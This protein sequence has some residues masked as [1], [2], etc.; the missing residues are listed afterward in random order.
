MENSTKKK[1]LIGGSVLVIAGV[2]GFFLW[3]YLKKKKEEAEKKKAEEEAA[4]LAASNTNT[5]VNVSSGGGGG[6][7]TSVIPSGTDVL[8]FQKFAN[9][10]GEKLTE[11]GKAGPKTNAAWTKWGAD[12]QKSTQANPAFDEAVKHLVSKGLS[13]TGLR[14]M[15]SDYVIAWA[16]ANKAGQATFTFGGK[17]YDSKTGNATTPSTPVESS[18]GKTIYPKSSYVNVRSSASAASGPFNNTFIGQINSPNA[19]GNVK[20]FTIGADKF[21]WYEVDLLTPLAQSTTGL[22]GW[23]QYAKTG[24][25]RE[26][27]IKFA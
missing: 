25:V 2:G 15:G 12:Y 3:K 6:G 23:N 11:D 9:S 1:L 27:A 17:Y 4:R 21:R 20:N 14:A 7:G 22:V 13:E 10:K 5:N 18:I 8:A 24:W 19:I 16:N 26:D